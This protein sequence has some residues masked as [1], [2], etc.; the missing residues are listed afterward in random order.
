VNDLE[1]HILL[2]DDEEMIA[3]SLSYQLEDLG[4]IICGTAGTAEEA[5]IMAD[6]HRPKVILMDVRLK[7]EKDGIDA[8]LTIHEHIGSR[9]I[10]LTGSTEPSTVERINLDHPYAI[11]FKPVS[12]RQLKTTVETAMTD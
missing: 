8:A 6:T 4:F 9:V 11:L 5:I 2:V 12:Y 10:F 3:M 7:G 1:H